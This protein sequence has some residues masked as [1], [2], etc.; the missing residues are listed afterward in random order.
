MEAAKKSLQG[1]VRIHLLISET[2][3]VESADIIS[4]DPDLANAALEAMKK[5]KFKPYIHNGKPVKVNTKMPFD[6][7]FQDKVADAKVPSESSATATGAP[8]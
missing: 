7:A 4:G 3:D 1:K 8:A 5:W 2:G 6:F